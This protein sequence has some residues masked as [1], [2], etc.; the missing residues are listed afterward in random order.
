MSERKVSTDALETLGTIIS[1]NEKRDAIHLA[2]LPV[3]ATMK[4]H[5]GDDVGLVEGGA[6]TK[7]ANLIG[8]VDPFL[9]KPVR[10]GERFW[11]VIYPRKI[12][13][14]RHVWSH[15][16]VDDADESVAK[17]SAKS[18]AEQELRQVA[19]SAG[20]TLAALLEGAREYLSHNEYMV[21]GGKWE[22]FSVPHDFWDHYE[23]HTGEKVPEQE[24]GNFFS[25]SC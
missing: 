6:S 17:P 25:C 9:T 20:L 8:I 14:L 18:H 13:S 19:D 24:R 21:Q 10:E 12:N 1:E 23:L 4:M 11:L 15:P 3:V 22:G 16:D 7:A 2:V 5:P